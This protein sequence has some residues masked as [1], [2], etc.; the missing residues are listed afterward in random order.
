M[1][2]LLYQPWFPDNVPLHGRGLACCAI[3][4]ICATESAGRKLKGAGPRVAGVAV[5]V[6]PGGLS[7]LRVW[8]RVGAGFQ[9][10]VLRRSRAGEEAGLGGGRA[11][12]RAH[13]CLPALPWALQVRWLC[14]AYWGCPVCPRQPQ[15][16]S[17]SLNPREDRRAVAERQ[18]FGPSERTSLLTPAMDSTASASPS[19]N[20]VLPP[21]R[22][23][24]E[25][26]TTSSFLKA[27][28]QNLMT[29]EDVAV[30]FTQWEWGQLNPAQ[31]DVYREVM[32]ENFRNLAFLGLLV[33]KPYVICQLEEGD[34]PF[35]V[36]RDISTGA[37]SDWERRS[38]SKESM[39]SWGISKEELFQVVSV[40][41]HIQDVLQ[42]SKL[43]A[44]CGCDGQLEMQQIKQQ[45]QSETDVNHSQIC[46]HP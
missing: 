38:K 33:S 42:F 10:L 37:D 35:I 18:R 21:E 39:P 43:K 17:R 30:E 24:G 36:E 3:L 5:A 19:Q 45:T 23:P 6:S 20:P 31:K 4:A 14:R 25:K 15:P 32:L 22:F 40:E 1:E 16:A 29:F 46:Y 13:P 41:K 12:R 34:E 26:G 11:R 27:R 9:S 28:P 2:K 7:P 8:I 44:A